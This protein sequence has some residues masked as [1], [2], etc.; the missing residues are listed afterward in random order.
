MRQRSYLPLPVD[1]GFSSVRTSAPTAS[2]RIVIVAKVGF[3]R[4]HSIC[5]IYGLLD[6]CLCLDIELGQARLDSGL[7]KVLAEHYEQRLRRTLGGFGT[8]CLPPRRSAAYCPWHPQLDPCVPA[9]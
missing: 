2:A 9:Q 7:V 6:A 5:E 8:W 1:G 3:C 4:P